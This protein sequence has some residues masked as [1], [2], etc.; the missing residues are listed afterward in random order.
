MPKLTCCFTGHRLLPKD[1]LDEITLRLSRQVD[2]MIAQGVCRFISGGALGF[3]QLAA[4][5]RAFV[6]DKEIGEVF[7]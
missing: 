4:L 7:A 5:V 3:D 6:C 1:R 2:E